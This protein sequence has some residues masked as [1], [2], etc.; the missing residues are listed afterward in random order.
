MS[1]CV[2]AAGGVPLQGMASA[3]VSVEELLLA[4]RDIGQGRRRLVLS[5]PGVH[6]GA[7]IRTV[8]DALNAIPAVKAARVNLSSRRVAIE[9]DPLLRQGLGEVVPA[10]TRQ[11][12][13]VHLFAADGDTAG[14]RN[15]A[16]LIR[17]LAVAGFAAANI[18]LLSVSVWAGADDATRD[19]FHW[20]SALI[21]APTVAY[22]GRVFYQSA[23][24][25][26]RSGRMNMDV[27]IALGV[28]LAFL[29]SLFETVNHGQ[30][31]YFD[32]SVSLLFF[33]LIGRVLDH[34]MR[35]RARSAVRGLAAL[36]PRAALVLAAD[37]SRSYLPVDELDVGMHLLVAAGERIPVDSTVLEGGS[38]VDCAL[39]TGESAPQAAMPGAVLRAGAL[40]LTGPLTLRADAKAQ[41]SFLA[42]MVQLV[43]AAEGGRAQYRRMADRMAAIYSPAVHVLAA[44]TLGFWLIV[45]GDWHQ[46]VMTAIAVLI[47]TCPCALGL[48]VPIVQV[49]AAGRLFEKGILL[50]DGA[51][52]EKLAE[53]D[54]VVFDKTGTL[55]T[56]QP[57][58]LNPAHTPYTSQ[59]VALAAQSG[60]PLS[61]AIVAQFGLPDHLPRFSAVQ[62]VPGF[63]IE[64]ESDGQLY[65]LGRADWGLAEWG[66]ADAGQQG[67]TQVVLSANGQVL[68]R[69]H[70]T[71]S[72]RPEAVEAV[73]E[74][75]GQG[76]ATGICSG[77]TASAVAQVGDALGIAA[78]LAG[79]LPADKIAHV[80]GVQQAGHRVLMVGDGLNDAPALAAA[81][82]SMAPASAADVGRN[83]ADLVFLHKSLRAIPQAVRI[84]RQAKRAVQQNFALAVV[85]NVIAVPIAFMG[86]CTPLVAALAMSL[87][88]VLVVANAL[89]LRLVNMELSR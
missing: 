85:Y 66:L 33:L 81:H 55:T 56:G 12:Y 52:L 71:D 3:G 42:E 87:S 9:F 29:M 38:E 73:A 34:M 77:D 86:Y 45:S 54:T 40:N 78:Q 48:A 82:V 24:A 13:A 59:A 68:Q 18:M 11:G 26:L 15:F 43:E 27:P 21:A 39:I 6:C 22:S 23:F 30:H 16:Q 74:L 19:M 72:L 25:A 64:G 28:S 50:K 5:V 63:G 46:A 88:S 57:V 32:A 61:R 49:V 51:A 4:S 69:F 84:A 20:L 44:V 65:R 7:C 62:E 47:I 79:C 58:L 17:A 37:G 83:A 53:A 41:D 8:E 89:R 36:M 1:C 35:E 10:I 31:A 80:Q 60:H 67:G 70:F 76:L 2:P 14:D 75:R